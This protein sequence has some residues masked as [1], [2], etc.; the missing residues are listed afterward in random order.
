MDAFPRGAE[1]DAAVCLR[2][3]E[4]ALASPVASHAP[5]YHYHYRLLRAAATRGLLQWHPE[6]DDCFTLT[7]LGARF[8]RCVCAVCGRLNN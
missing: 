8:Q 6:R 4:I 7:A 5:H 2:S 3:E 1:D